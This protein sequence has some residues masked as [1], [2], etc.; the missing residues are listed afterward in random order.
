MEDIITALEKIKAQGSFCGLRR[1]SINKLHI[2]IKGFGQLKL[3][4]TARKAKTLIKHAKPAKFGWRDQTLLDK[5]VRNAWEISKSN[6]KIDTSLWNEE[7]KSVLS[8]LKKDLG[9]PDSATLKANLHNLLIYEP[10]QFFSPH[11]DSEKL[12]GMV[13]SLVIVLPS[14]HRGG[15]LIIDHQGEKKQFQTSRFPLDKLTF[16]AFYADCHHEVKEIKDGHR[17][18]LTYNLVLEH[19]DKK[20]QPPSRTKSYDEVTQSLRSYFTNEPDTKETSTRC[21]VP[22]KFIYLL[23]H[24]YTQSGLSWNHLKNGDSL[25]AE[26]LKAVADALDSVQK[27]SLAIFAREIYRCDAGSAIIIF[28]TPKSLAG[29]ILLFQFRCRVIAGVD[30]QGG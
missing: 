9:L 10:G 18:T 28:A 11:Q 14:E 16:I 8:I 7:L 20:V 6:I 4:F 29:L 5:T 19:H 15:S 1:A 24:S 25:R 12:D 21:K 3:P 26:V 2:E 27:Q 13:A 22:K 30:E 17:V 23:D